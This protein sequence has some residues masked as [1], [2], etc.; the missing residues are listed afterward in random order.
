MEILDKLQP[1]DKAAILSPSFG[2]PGTWPHVYQLGLERLRG[3]G[4]EPVEFPTT[5]QVNALAKD[6]AAGERAARARCA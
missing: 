4:L 6:R 3:F 2:A 1:G 5:T